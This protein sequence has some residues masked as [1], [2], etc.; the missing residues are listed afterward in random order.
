MAEVHKLGLKLKHCKLCSKS[1]KRKEHL[2]RHI[3]T[4]HST[5]KKGTA[6]GKARTKQRISSKVM[7]AKA[8]THEGR[9]KPQAK[10]MS[11]N[12]INGKVLNLAE[13]LRRLWLSQI[14]KSD[15]VCL[16]TTKVLC[17]EDLGQ[18]FISMACKERT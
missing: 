17:V 13:Y 11:P 16:Y 14:F 10:S 4:V 2:K 3:A 9:S 12:G 7:E 1:F 15:S 18:E 8:V 6:K 5:L